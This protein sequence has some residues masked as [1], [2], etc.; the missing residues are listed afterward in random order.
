MFKG[1]EAYDTL[2]SDVYN[3]IH[4]IHEIPKSILRSVF[5][6]SYDNLY[7]QHGDSKEL[8]EAL[9]KECRVVLKEVHKRLSE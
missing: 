8:D 2:R 5:A 1:T 7:A 9:L 4:N 6:K 3:D